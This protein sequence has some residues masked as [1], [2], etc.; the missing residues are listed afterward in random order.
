MNN[1]VLRKPIMILKCCKIPLPIT[2]NNKCRCNYIKVI[3]K[4]IKIWSSKINKLQSVEYI[5]TIITYNDINTFINKNRHDNDINNKKREAIIGCIIND[6]LPND[7]YKKSFRWTN[8]KKAIDLYIK[9]LC[10]YKNIKDLNKISCIHKAG[11]TNHYDFKI[12]INDSIDFNI[13]F[14]FNANCL[15]DTPQFVSPMKPSQYL[16]Y[17]YEEFYYDNYF[18][19][20][21]KDYNLDLPNKEEYLKEIHSIKPKCL[22]T[23]QKKYYCGCKKSSKYSGCNNDIEFYESMKKISK[24]SIHD[25]IYKYDLNID[26]LTHYILNTQKDKFYMLYKNDNINLETINQDNYKITEIIKEPKLSRFIAKTN[27]GNK[28]TILLRW[29]NGNG[30]AFPSFQIS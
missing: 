11:R 5:D 13:E 10:E 27:N 16:T 24:D 15:N 14:K 29:K 19:K 21:V 23:H 25:F 8:L 3:Q 4:N 9:K 20:I 18:K 2:D 7:Y 28:L 26:K 22:I 17:S 6:K 30:I 1:I 12:L